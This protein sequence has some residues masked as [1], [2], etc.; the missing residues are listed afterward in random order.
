MKH[1]IRRIFQDKP[2]LK[3][4]DNIIE[5]NPGGVGVPIGSYVS[6][7]LANFYLTD[8]DNWLVDKGEYVV[9]YMDDVVVIH[10]SKR[11]LQKLLVEMEQYLTDLKLTVKG[12]KQIFPIAKRGIDF[13]GYRFFPGYVLLRKSTCVTL[14]QCCTRIFRKLNNHKLLS[15]REFCSINSYI[16]WLKHCNSHRLKQK[17]IQP[18]IPKLIEYYCYVIHN[19]TSVDKKSKKVK[20]YINRLIHNLN[21]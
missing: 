13:I 15:K 16:G 2:L 8:F 9:R 5:S 18:V 10:K 7:F 17:Y 1:Q 4:L 20:K 12:N 21:E 6:Q 19:S 11:H 3:I 14:K